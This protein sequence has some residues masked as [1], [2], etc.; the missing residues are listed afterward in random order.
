MG[1]TLVTDQACEVM[2]EYMSSVC[3]NCSSNTS[4]SGSEDT[5][6][7]FYFS[8]VEGL[9]KGAVGLLDFYLIPKCCSFL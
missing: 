5:D 1:R 2:K 9:V 3:D 6:T 4:T 8:N 7:E